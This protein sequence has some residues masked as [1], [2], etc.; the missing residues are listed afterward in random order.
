MATLDAN[1]WVT[2]ADFKEHLNETGTDKDD[3]LTNILNSAYGIAK[4]YIGHDLKAADYTEYH[5][6]EG[7]ND[8]LLDVWPINTIASIYD[9]VDRDFGADT[10][11]DST[12]YFFD[13]KTG[14]VTL[15]QGQAAFSAGLGNI[16]VTYNAGYS[17]VP[18]DAQRGLI[19]LGAWL[20]Q[21]AGT[22]GMSAQTLGGKSEQYEN[23]NIPLYIRQC[24]V[25][26]KS[27]SA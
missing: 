20:A 6:G 7:T 5:N 9:D 25:P 13:A 19:L 14:L 26:Y 27:F 4:S 11:V 8:L 18:Y 12:D 22:E 24:F 21:R 17:T 15:F 16:K 2:L 23:T 3:F 10:L 1:V